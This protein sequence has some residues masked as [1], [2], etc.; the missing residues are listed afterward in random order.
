MPGAGVDSAVPAG[1]LP[2]RTRTRA[3][4][5]RSRPRCSA[6]RCSR[7]SI[8]SV[9]TS[10]PP[11]RR[12]AT[13]C[14]C[15]SNRSGRRRNAASRW[16]SRTRYDGPGHADLA[17]LARSAGPR[18]LATGQLAVLFLQYR[19]SPSQ[20]SSNGAAT[21]YAAICASFICRRSSCRSRSA[22]RPAS[23]PRPSRLAPASRAP[24]A[25]SPPGS[26]AASPGA[27]ARSATGPKCVRNSV[28][29]DHASIR[30]TLARHASTSMSGGGV[31]G[32]T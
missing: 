23:A 21:G 16:R 24:T 17:N 28:S 14:G 6:A 18:D 27:A 3:A 30:S 22:K 26:P 13:R 1:A 2:G 29:G 15:W 25:P 7:R 31:G 10:R 19:A 8:A 12:R 32:R 20:S 11:A 9:R 5:I 4:G